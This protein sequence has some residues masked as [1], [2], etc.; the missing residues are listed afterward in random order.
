MFLVFGGIDKRN[1]A[2]TRMRHKLPDK[3]GI[4]GQLGGI[5]RLKLQ[6]FALLVAKPLA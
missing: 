3:L 6:P 1:R 2:P 4:V 5:P